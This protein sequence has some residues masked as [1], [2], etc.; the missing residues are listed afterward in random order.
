MSKNLSVEFKYDIGEVVL[1]KAGVEDARV[2]A[3]SGARGVRPLCF[4][5]KERLV[6]QCPGGVQLL[7]MLG[8][9]AETGKPFLEHE[10]VPLADY[11]AEAVALE[12]M[13]NSLSIEDRAFHGRGDA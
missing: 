8:Y 1:T 4:T 6:Q 9:P 3:R 10:L 7:Y 12:T 11:D 13:K 2:A 5:V